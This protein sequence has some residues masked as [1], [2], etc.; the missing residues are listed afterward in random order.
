MMVEEA[1]IVINCGS[2]SV[3]FALFSPEF[4]SS[5]RIARGAVERIGIGAGRFSVLDGSGA[6]ILDETLEVE[7]H[8]AAI[9]A[10]LDWLQ[11]T[12]YMPVSVGHRIVHG[13]EEC[14]CSL[15]ITSDLEDRLSRL[16]PLAPLH[17]PHNLTGIKAVKLRCPELPQVACFDTAFHHGLP[18]VAQLTGLPRRFDDDSIRRFGFHGLSYEYVVEQV[19][20]WH[21]D[22]AADGKIV[23]AHLGN[24]ASMTAIKGGRSIETSMGFSTLAGLPMGTRPGDLDPGAVLY[25]LMEKNLTPAELQH[26]LY[27]ESGVLGR[28]GLSRN[29]RD[30]LAQQ[31]LPEAA[32]A[33][34][35]FCH[36]ARRHLAAQTASLGGLDRLV[37][38]GGI[39]ANSPEIRARICDGLSYLGVEIDPDRNAQNLPVVST[40][41]SRVPIDAFDTDEESVIARHVRTVLESASGKGELNACA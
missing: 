34:E 33:I 41:R 24:G 15:I 29:M 31:D 13:G 8:A 26:I 7:S 9:D 2:S 28:S 22:E 20:R 38:T 21:G 36:H 4:E 25:L 19:R 27:R 14:D 6:T 40:D 30:L 17:L 5:V 35:F 12:Q 18:R 37:F 32:E 39:G 23:A 10:L 16:I 3:K 1:I 11:G